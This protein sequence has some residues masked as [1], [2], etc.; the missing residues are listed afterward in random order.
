MGWYYKA[1]AKLM[2]RLVI[3]SVAVYLLLILK[4]AW[5]PSQFVPSLDGSWIVV[6]HYAFSVG[7]GFGREI[8][9]PFGPYGFVWTDTYYPSTF[10]LMLLAQ[11]FI[12]LSIA[13]G[14]EHL[15]YRRISKLWLALLWL[16]AIIVATNDIYLLCPLVFFL[17]YHLEGDNHARLAT[18]LLL[19]AL[20]LV[21]LIKFTY[22][23]ISFWILIILTIEDIFRARRWPWFLTLFT[24]YFLALWVVAGQDIRDIFLFLKNSLEI[25]QGYSAA[26]AYRNK[27]WQNMLP[28][29]VTVPFLLWALA[30]AGWKRERLRGLLHAAGLGGIL[31]LIFKASF[32]RHD[33]H[34]ILALLNAPVITLLYIPFL[35]RPEHGRRVKIPLLVAL[36]ASLWPALSFSK[37][38]YGETIFKSRIRHLA[39]AKDR[40]VEAFR[41]LRGKEKWEELK[42]D[43]EARI[44]AL[45]F[46]MPFPKPRGS[47]DLYSFQ[48]GYVIANGFDYSPRPVFQSCQ[49][50]TPALA[51]LN[52]GHLRGAHAPDTIFFMVMPIDWRLPALEDALSWPELL[53]RYDLRE[54]PGPFLCLERSA[55]PRTFK[56]TQVT[57]I[58]ASFG[59]EV[60]L[61]Q[62]AKGPIWAK[63]EIRP[64]FL[65]RIA[66]FL[67][68]VYPP[69][70]TINDYPS[71]RLIP[72]LARAGFL[73]SP[74]VE[75]T[76]D[77]KALV[78]NP[79]GGRVV[80]SLRVEIDEVW[81]RFYRPQI[82]IRLFRL[83]LAPSE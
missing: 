27:P 52:A 9:F 83:E 80:K 61:L 74:Y 71:R 51:E 66:N 30:A 13:V 70:I 60:L 15:A 8:V 53:T 43:Y 62:A 81:E 14:M 29:L 4:V 38:I 44:A 6:L 20:P 32:V 73:L 5:E 31:F 22:F 50:Y 46:E 36:L 75:D 35:W 56:L 28:Y 63:I 55:K 37:C 19:L 1:M 10:I 17:S 40:T 16:A 12:C 34:D 39:T 26:M 25:S 78:V 18:R 48:Q 65:Y 21:S 72:S 67:Y 76:S 47:V 54:S 24:V 79:H 58:K 59:E 45:R 41:L 49:A 3:L 7:K 77:F 82:I 69:L 68:K 11:G 57:E 64:T 2:R 42:R 33:E 23:M